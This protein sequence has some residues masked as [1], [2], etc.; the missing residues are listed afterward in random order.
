MAIDRL[1]DKERAAL[2]S[3]ARVLELETEVP[4][5]KKENLALDDLKA[6]LSEENIELK[7]N[8]D[9]FVK[10]CSDLVQEVET[11]EKNSEDNLGVLEKL[12]STIEKDL[13]TNAALKKQNEALAKACA[14]KD[15][16]IHT[17]GKNLEDQK[18]FIDGAE[19][20]LK[21]RFSQ[22]HDGYKL[23]LAEF[24]AE[25]LPF[26][27]DKGANEMFDWMDQ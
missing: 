16:M 3:S 26:S 13:T 25:P 7:K 1:Q 10:T 12:R 27:A 18:G 9:I 14:E 11:F 24:G 15:I 8:K 19:Q 5:L 4:R 2:S 22:I 23:V 21:A 6:S 20:V 17:L